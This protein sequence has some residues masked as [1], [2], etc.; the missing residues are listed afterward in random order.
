M[1]IT[2]IPCPKCK[3]LAI[4]NGQ[5]HKTDPREYRWYCVAC[6][7]GGDGYSYS[8]DDR[9]GAISKTITNEEVERCFYQRNATLKTYIKDCQKNLESSAIGQE[10]LSSRGVIKT[11]IERYKIGYGTPG[12]RYENM[13]VFPIWNH[14]GT[15]VGVSCRNLSDPNKPKYVNSSTTDTFQK[16]WLLFGQLDKLPE[17]VVLVEGQF[18]VLSI[19][20]AGYSALA[21]LGG[22]FSAAHDMILKERGVKRI[23]SMMDGDTAGRAYTERI[24]TISKLNVVDCTCPEGLDPGSMTPEQIQQHLS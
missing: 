1:Q 24:K 16:H 20:R 2:Q 5:E 23:I 21:V 15:L 18:D 9:I 12:S 14:V 19:E 22:A 10:Y 7:E 6:G 11:Q 3:L 17:E 8:D 13:I 4:A